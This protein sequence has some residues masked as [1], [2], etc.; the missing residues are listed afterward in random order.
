METLNLVS[1]IIPS[2][3]RA[4]TL[5]RAI[6]SAL[7]QTYMNMEVLVVDDNIAGDEYSMALQNIINEYKEDKRVKLVTQP[8]H[9][10]GAEARNAGIRAASGEWIAFLDD[11]DEW[12]PSKI[13]KQMSFLQKHPEVTGASCYYN[14]YVDGKLVHSCPPYT[15]EDLNFKV[16]TRQIAMYTP[17]LLMR[18]DRLMDFGGFDNRL[19]RHQDLQLLAEYTHR[20]EMLVVE[21]FL[22]NV[23]GD[24]L[25]NRP[26]LENLIKVK[27]DYFASIANVFESYPKHKQTLIK[28]AHYYEVVFCALK[29]K[30][31]GVAIKYA[32]KAGI[33][34]EA[35]K[36]LVKRFKDKKFIAKCNYVWQA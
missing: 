4:D 11:D 33:H 25:T 27:K 16:L 22:V 24:S 15:T 36:M 30:N 23:Y 6:N 35:L 2:Y 13:E 19:E 1:C 21:E 34:L 31:I 14:E 5:R 32:V 7:A 20:N 28:C 29:V 18:K 26:S 8:K 10:N 3:K 17:T 12:L 9:I